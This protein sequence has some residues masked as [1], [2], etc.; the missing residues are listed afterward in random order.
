[1]DDGVT[2]AIIPMKQTAVILKNDQASSDGWGGKNTTGSFS[3]KCRF[4]ERSQLYKTTAGLK[5]IRD[6][7]GKE[8]VF[9]GTFTFN[10]SVD[11]N[12]HDK[13]EFTNEV[14]VSHV[15][16]PITIDVIRNLSGKVIATLVEVS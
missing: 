15:Y 10:K 2:M 6:S 5:D 12:L 9:K 16:T 3:I 13:I 7:K 1:M 8:V 11:L 14:G 4:V